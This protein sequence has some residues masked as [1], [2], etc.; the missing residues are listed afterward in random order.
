MGRIS[1]V[2]FSVEQNKNTNVLWM[3][4]KS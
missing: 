3:L 4:A 1:D 2:W